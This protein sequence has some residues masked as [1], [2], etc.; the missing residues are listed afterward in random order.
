[1]YMLIV[2]AGVGANIGVI[3]GGGGILIVVCAGIYEDNNGGLK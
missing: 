1:M 2:G 3:D